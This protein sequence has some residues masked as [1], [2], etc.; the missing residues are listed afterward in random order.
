VG[1]GKRGEEKKKKGEE[2]QGIWQRPSAKVS[3][4]PDRLGP[5]TS[6]SKRKKKKRKK[7]KKRGEGGQ[8]TCV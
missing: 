1:E 5:T 4:P 3:C 2:G 6:R 7:K 8:K